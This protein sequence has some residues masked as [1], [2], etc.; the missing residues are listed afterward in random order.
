MPELP[1]VK[2]SEE[3]NFLAV[4]FFS[5]EEF[6]LLVP[7]KNIDI[8]CHVPSMRCGEELR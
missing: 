3:I 7:L 8:I 4:G 2:E 5:S 6:Q 1:T